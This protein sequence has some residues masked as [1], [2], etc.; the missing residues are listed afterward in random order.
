MKVIS[1]LSGVFRQGE[2]VYGVPATARRSWGWATP[3]LLMF[4]LGGVVF[5]AT[6]V[7][8]AALPNGVAT[9]TLAV[10]M[11]WT[12]LLAIT[13]IA[14]F[15]AWGLRFERR[16]LASLGLV[17]PQWRRQV[18][19]GLLAGIGICLAIGVL[20]DMAS[21][22]A[23]APAGNGGGWWIFQA[24]GS[25]VSL[26]PADLVRLACFVAAV[27]IY[28]AAEEVVFRG[29]LLS[30]ISARWGAAPGI[31]LSSALFASYHY[32]LFGGGLAYGSFWMIAMGFSGV[33]F[34]LL[35]MVQKSLFGAIGMHAGFNLWLMLGSSLPRLS[36]PEAGSLSQILS[37]TLDVTSGMPEDGGLPLTGYDLADAIVFALV[38][39]G[40]LQLVR[41][42]PVR[43]ARNP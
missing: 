6:I 40:L 16:S 29:W 11:M 34:C 42:Q 24:I 41:R 8:L 35:A 3:L 10:E 19:Q 38:G 30:A 9:I 22:F 28:A 37:V 32:H 14:V 7:W 43:F 1:V 23:G 20:G 2:W 33:A 26:G 17:D 27:A 21:W 13:A 36:D 25:L 5:V 15:T 12:V 31:L 18:G 4:G 39:L